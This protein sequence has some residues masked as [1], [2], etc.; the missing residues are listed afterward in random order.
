MLADYPSK[1]LTPFLSRLPDSMTA[2]WAQADV[3]AAIAPW[4]SHWDIDAVSLSV[5]SMTQICIELC[6][7]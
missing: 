7:R 6:Q 4:I 3:L 2:S 5:A 1:D